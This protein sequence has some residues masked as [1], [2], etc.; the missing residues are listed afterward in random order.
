[1]DGVMRYGKRVSRPLVVAVLS[2]A[3]LAWGCGS[4]PEP[5]ESQPPDDP[6][7]HAALRLTLATTDTQLRDELD[8]IIEEQGTPKLLAAKTAT[9]EKSVATA[10][11][12]LKWDESV[13]S[14]FAE[15]EKFF[16]PGAFGFGREELDQAIAFGRP[17]DKQRRASREA[18]Q[19]EDCRFGIDF[20][21]GF[22][23]DLSF[24][25]TVRLC[26]R[27]EAFRAAEQHAEGDLAEA[28]RSFAAMF[29]WAACLAA[30]PHAEVRLQGT[31]VRA[32]ALAV[33][34]VLVQHPAITQEHLASLCQRIEDQLTAWPSDGDAWI[35]DRA[36]GL[37]FYEATRAGELPSLLTTKEIERLSGTGIFQRL[38]SDEAVR[39]IDQDERYYLDAMRRIIDGCK[40]PLYT[41]GKIFGQIRRELAQW[42]SS[43]GHPVIAEELLLANMYEAH[44]I[45]ARD[46]AHCEVWALALAH[47]ARRPKPD[48]TVNPE[49][50]KPY[51]LEEDRDK[52]LILLRNVDTGP[53]GIK[54]MV[55][56]PAPLGFQWNKPP[57]TAAA[58][59]DETQE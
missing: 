9:G 44:A 37:F 52:G 36:L 20:N 24:V 17:Y 50:G 11:G 30:E 21:S 19:S 47:A 40:Q 49:T 8:R 38:D 5:E 10:L 51:V 25:D 35:G 2:G 28:I 43:E 55:V 56:I 39:H 33:L 12:E 41:R 26:V 46:R 15:S 53:H 34:R 1:M 14:I 48:F 7:D 13:A 22:S 4:E 3:V 59:S 29:Q 23:A 6:L 18:L 31:F 45:Q 32:E 16:P 54:N 42:P 27:L 57:D 58:A